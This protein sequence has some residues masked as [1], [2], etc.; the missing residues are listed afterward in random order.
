MQFFDRQV[1]NLKV[2]DLSFTFQEYE[3]NLFLQCDK[4]R[5]MVCHFNCL[6]L[7]LYTVEMFINTLKHDSGSC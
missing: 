2:T 7:M 5:M 3:D 4:C 6:T 1:I